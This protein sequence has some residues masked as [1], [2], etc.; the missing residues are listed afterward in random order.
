M[1]E[2]AGKNTINKKRTGPAKRAIRLK[3]MR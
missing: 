3:S 1:P 2:G